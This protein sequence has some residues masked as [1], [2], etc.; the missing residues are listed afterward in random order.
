MGQLLDMV[1][2]AVG[3]LVAQYPRQLVIGAHGFQQAGVDINLA[4]RQRKSVDGFVFNNV[5]MPGK[6]KDMVV[7]EAGGNFGSS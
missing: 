1:M 7:A 3:H 6:R 5:K 2:G 4:A